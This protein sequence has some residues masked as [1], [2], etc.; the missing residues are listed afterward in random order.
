[1]LKQRDNVSR[2]YLTQHSTKAWTVQSQVKVPVQR[3]HNIINWI[4]RYPEDSLNPNATDFGVTAD[5]DGVFAPNL[6]WKACGKQFSMRKLC[7]LNS[8]TLSKS[9]SCD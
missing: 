4:N 8:R 5:S 7:V 2:N 9:K 1:M 3:L 6:I